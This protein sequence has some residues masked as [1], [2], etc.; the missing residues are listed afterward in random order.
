M[1]DAQ[2]SFTTNN[3][4]KKRAL[5]QQGSAARAAAPLLGSVRVSSFLGCHA[6]WA[7]SRAEPAARANE[8]AQF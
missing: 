6:R 7:S 1:S 4:N 2:V 3:N 5:S 8:R